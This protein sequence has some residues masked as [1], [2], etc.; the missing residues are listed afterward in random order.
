M[1]EELAAAI[2]AEPDSP[3]A[4]LVYGDWLLE[5][6]DPLGELVS[7]QARLAKLEQRAGNAKEKNA[8]RRRVKALLAD[9]ESRLG[10]LGR[11]EHTWSLGFLESLVVPNPSTEQYEAIL[12]APAARFLRELDI[13]EIPSTAGIGTRIIA[14]I[15]RL[16]VPRALRK[17]ALS[18]KRPAFD[19]FGS[20]P[21]ATWDALANLTELTIAAGVIVPGAIALPNLETLSLTTPL[22][23]EVLAALEAAEWPH[24]RA[25][26]LDAV[27]GELRSPT[28]VTASRLAPLFARWVKQGSL[29]H[30]AVTEH[31][32]GD[33]LVDALFRSG[34]VHE[35]TTL[36]LS[37]TRLTDAGARTLLTHAADLAHLESMNLSENELSAATSRALETTFDLVVD[38]EEQGT[39]H[40]EE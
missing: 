10:P 35:L 4:Y 40:D 29:R 17:L 14:A 18:Q 32:A 2:I 23:D 19:R 30:L 39:R 26:H 37:R 9:A 22:T 7:V 15:A 25:A 16:G 38:V 5:H 11:Y 34:L 6:G 8:L 27:D 33:Q 36:D 31:D 21:P 12:A 20:I 13:E 3:D 1:T 24:L 28:A